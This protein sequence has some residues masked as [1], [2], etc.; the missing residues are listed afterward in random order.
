MSKPD[1]ARPAGDDTWTLLRAVA[2][3]ALVALGA[4]TVVAFDAPRNSVAPD[5]PLAAMNEAFLAADGP[6]PTPL[7]GAQLSVRATA[8]ADTRTP[9][10]A[11]M[12]P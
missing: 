4:L 6:Q 7:H 11:E 8:L 2:L 9:A 12:K 5:A 3:I 10:V 1:L